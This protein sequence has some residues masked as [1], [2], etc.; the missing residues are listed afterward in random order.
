MQYGQFDEKNREYIIERPDT[1][2]PWSNYLGSASFGA[3]I[4]NHGGGYTFFKSAAQGRL[5]R[6][7]F[8]EVPAQQP[9][10]YV[11]L[12][13]GESG[14]FWSN[15]WLPVN[16]VDSSF[17]YAC[18]HGLG[19]TRI[20]SVYRGIRC[21]VTYFIPLNSLYEV[22]QIRVRNESSRERTIQIFPF[23][24]P[25]CN[26]NALDDSTNL[27]YTQYIAQTRLIDGIIDIASNIN[28]PEDP[29]H[30]ENKDQKRHTFFAVTGRM[31]D[32][33]DG[34]LAEFI[35]PYG[36]Y[37]RP[38]AVEAG[39]CRNSLAYSDNPC[40][41]FQLNLQLGPGAS[42]EFAVVFGVGQAEKEG[43]AVVE[44]MRDSQ[45]RNEALAAIREH[46]QSRLRTL[47]AATPDPLFNAMVNTWAPYNNLM[48]FYWSRTA[49]LV[50][51]GER[52]GLG[53]RDTVQDC[54]GSV[55]LIPEETRQRLELM[56][57]GQLSNGGALP[58]VKPFA[59][60]P[61]HE[62]EPPHYRADD[63]LWLFMAVPEYIK[64]T[65]DLDFIN[66]ILP[67]ADK[68]EDTVLG[69]LERA[70]YFN[71]ER[72]GAHGLPCGLFA[73]WNDCV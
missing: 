64:E 21:E 42:D 45:K 55:A 51:A 59:H 50:Y 46:W 1:P 68:G 32:G 14:E 7:R 37:A 47:Q 58:V 48:T 57:T 19:Y 20:L 69:H 15:G 54:V 4:T 9:G 18:H 33:Y 53:Y 41:A 3:V 26:W 56:I 31:P 62:Q 65:G 17:Q 67:Y 39:Q 36:T 43:R 24:E 60:R 70:I 71:L 23:L 38:A 49:S 6:Y 27:Q 16:T 34:D 44:Q 10:K 22:W 63:C 40:G 52:D 72:C 11:Y 35:G 2:R 28:M 66:R 13:D 29:E 12:R 25:Q 61:G 73:D 5:T 30:F 8:N